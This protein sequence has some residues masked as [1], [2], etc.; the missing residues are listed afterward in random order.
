MTE[1]VDYYQSHL[2][3]LLQEDTIRA[4]NNEPP[5]LTKEIEDTSENKK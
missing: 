2:Q 4:R 5:T 3:E 1:W